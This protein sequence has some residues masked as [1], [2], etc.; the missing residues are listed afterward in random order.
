MQMGVA[1]RECPHGAEFISIEEI[2]ISFNGN[3][4]VDVK[5]LTSAEPRVSFVGVKENGDRLE[6]ALKGSV[7]LYYD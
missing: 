5:V 7:C 3:V 2:A 1:I 6:Q 4:S